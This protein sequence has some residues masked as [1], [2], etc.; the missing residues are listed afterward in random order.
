M[1]ALEEFDSGVIKHYLEDMFCIYGGMIPRVGH[2]FGYFVHE[3]AHE[4]CFMICYY[5]RLVCRITF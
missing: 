3:K 4:L 1:F 2:V 5:F